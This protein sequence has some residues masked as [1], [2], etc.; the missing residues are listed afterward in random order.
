MPCKGA[1]WLLLDRFEGSLS[2]P[3]LLRIGLVDVD[4]ILLTR[5]RCWP[6]EILGPYLRLVLACECL[7]RL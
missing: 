1:F 3:P 4:L 2:P 6:Y 7:R 5:L